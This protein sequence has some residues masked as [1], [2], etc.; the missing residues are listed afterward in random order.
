MSSSK[1]CSPKGKKNFKQKLRENSHEVM[2]DN[3]Y[4]S[5]VALQDFWRSLP[6]EVVVFE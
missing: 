6:G 3:G 2:L 1:Y 4:N 5:R